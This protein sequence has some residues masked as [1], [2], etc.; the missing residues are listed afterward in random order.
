MWDWTGVR[1]S[2]SK[3]TL[4]NRKARTTLKSWEENLE[5]KLYPTCMGGMK[6]LHNEA[7]WSETARGKLCMNLYNTAL[8]TIHQNIVGIIGM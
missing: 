1:E 2:E 6:W 5:L 3:P 7:G 4:Y 8:A